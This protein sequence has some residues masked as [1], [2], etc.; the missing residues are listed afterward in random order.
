MRRYHRSIPALVLAMALT[1][2]LTACGGSGSQSSAPAGN[3]SQSSGS[4]TPES[5][6]PESA[7][8]E[9]PFVGPATPTETVLTANQYQQCLQVGNTVLSLDNPLRLGDFLAAGATVSDANLSEGYLMD[10][11]GEKI[12]SLLVGSTTLQVYFTNYG[13][14]RVALGECEA[15]R[16]YGTTRGSDVTYAGGITVGGSL[17][18]LTAI[19][20][21]PTEDRSK[22]YG[23]EL[24]YLYL[25]A[26]VSRELLTD[27]ITMSSI[28]P[29]VSATGNS[30]T[31]VIDRNTSTITNIQMNWNVD[32]G[33]R[34][35]VDTSPIRFGQNEYDFSWE[36]PF[37]LWR[38]ELGK[39]HFVGLMTLDEVPYVVVL[40]ANFF[41]LGML[42]GHSEAAIGE[43]IN[44]T[45]SSK[46]YAVQILSTSEGEAKAIG[47]LEEDGM[48]R[49]VL[50]YFVGEH[51]YIS[52]ASKI[53]PLREGDSLT[54][55]AKEEFLTLATGFLA[56]VRETAAK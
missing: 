43:R 42:K 53:L 9:G 39:N 46:Q 41:G 19:W 50:G 34:T 28:P 47:T 27:S 10:P 37:T 12:V 14:S 30:Y 48:L 40:D 3:S 38:S 24:T 54:D 52:S 33:E 25:E 31:V 49:V 56:T 17:S 21:E 7:S 22:S 29:M 18:D 23:D 2:S 5:S 16:I 15:T 26:P 13:E 8:Q 20:G 44:P 32:A 36:L 35:H 6:T 1:L 11:K 51:S 55:E 45:G 4:S